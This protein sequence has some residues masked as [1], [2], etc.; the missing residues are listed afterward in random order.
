MVRSGLIVDGDFNL[1]G[2][3]NMIDFSMLAQHWGLSSRMGPVEELPGPA[4]YW[5]L[6]ETYGTITH[7]FSPNANHGKV[8]GADWNPQGK[9]NFAASFDSQYDRIEIPTA[10]M[11]ISQGTISLWCRLN[12]GSQPT[13]HLY[14]FGHATPPY[15]S[16]RIQLYM[17]DG[18]RGLDLGLG[19]SHTASRGIKILQTET[20]YHIALTRNR[21]IYR[22]FVD[23]IP[24]ASGTY[25]GLS[26]LNTAADIGNDGR[27]D[28]SQRNEAFNGLL[29]D[30]R[31][32]NYA[33]SSPEIAYLAALDSSYIPFPQDAF[34]FDL[35]RD[36]EI[37]LRDLRVFS[38]NWLAGK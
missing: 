3:V 12:P 4:G 38:E 27:L 17:N 2:S 29:D 6:D 10:A 5:P 23:G 7:D 36:N 18:D 20:W 32:Y 26:S 15:F 34:K 37:D 33:L 30:V 1:D 24:Q 35:Y 28:G 19:N 8:S 21:S 25:S 14:L 31:L 9:F 16:N 13:R 22:V 11:S